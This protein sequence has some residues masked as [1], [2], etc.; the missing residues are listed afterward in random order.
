MGA[1]E[2]SHAGA[3]NCRVGV[4][5]LT[6]AGAGRCRLRVQA[7]SLM[8]A[9]L[10]LI[11]APAAGQPGEPRVLVT[12]GGGAQV[13]G[14]TTDRIE[15]E[16]HRETATAT[17]DYGVGASRLFGGG[18]GIRLWRQVGAGV[19]VSA[20]SRTGTAAVDARI[21]HPFFF[22]QAREIGGDA[23]SLTRSET[24]VHVQVLYVVPSNGRRRIVLAA[25]PSRFRLEQDVVT[26]VRFTEQFPFDEAAFQRADTLAR[27]ASAVGFNVGADVAYMFTRTLGLA[28][29]A[30][31]ARATVALVRPGGGRTRVVAGGL[32]GGMGLRFA[33]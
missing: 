8:G 15:W 20:A 2:A 31:F 27:R 18:L 6:R 11:A 9:L 14:A 29:T 13:G 12:I 24:G 16:E 25:G 10:V 22:D 26:T 32:Q 3:E 1:G 23:P 21:P 17:V 4:R 19:A 5:E 28:G 33:F 30:R 7:R